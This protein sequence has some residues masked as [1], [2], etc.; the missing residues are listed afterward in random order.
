MLNGAM[1]I[2]E[3]QG[4]PLVIVNDV[5]KGTAICLN[6]PFNYDEHYP[7]PDSLYYYLTD[8]NHARMLKGIIK[9]IFTAHG[10]KPLIAVWTKNNAWPWGFETWFYTDGKA[11]YVGLTKRRA[12]RDEME[13]IVE[14]KALDKGHLYD[15]FKKEYI[16]S[17][18][19][20]KVNL[21]PADVHLYS[22]L[23]YKVL[24]INVLL[25]K[26]VIS[27]GQNVEGV[28][29]I[30][31]GGLPPVRHV[32]HLSVIRPDGKQ[33]HYMAQNLETYN[34]AGE[35]SIPTALNEVPGKYLFEL[36]DVATGIR[37]KKSFIIQPR[38]EA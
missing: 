9:T 19:S 37:I 30:D 14:I 27:Q 8:P 7:T 23:P 34:G 35:F 16:G 28:V 20:W 21:K 25:D 29:Q 26:I 3:V 5:G 11:Q 36:S 31:T 17:A 18:G 4:V 15:M 24:N 22:L 2:V 1:P 38:K 33:V 32:L 13:R 10:I 6:I 12:A